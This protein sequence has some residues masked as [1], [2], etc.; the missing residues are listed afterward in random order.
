MSEG[1]ALCE[2]I[3]RDGRLADYRIIEINPALQGMLGVGPE[4]AGTL[5][6]E[7]GPV[8]RPW[9]EVCERVLLEG[10]PVGFEFHNRSTG[11]WHEIRLTRVAKDRIAQFFFD[12]T[13]R[14]EAQEHQ[15]R[16]FDELN[17]RVKNSLTM[18]SALLQMQART[19]APEAR[20]A[21]SR[22]VSRVAAI[23]DVHG[24]LHA[25]P[26]GGEAETDLAPY[27]ETLCKRLE[28]SLV[29]GERIVIELTAE[30]VKVTVD[31]AAPLGM[32]VN[33][34]VT[35]SVKHAYP[36]PSEGVIAV[37]LARSP[38]GMVLTVRDWGP[39]VDKSAQPSIG[40]GLGMN[41][42][43]SLARQ[44]GA[45]FTTRSGPGT[46]FELRLPLGAPARQAAS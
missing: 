45:T 42:I 13:E 39:G 7:G 2:P 37:R 20:E 12:I 17:H 14:K 38:S 30:P 46:T 24:A 10:E 21:L 31:Q 34:L 1:F 23:S 3:W 18:V 19:A 36:P 27:L 29:E 41:L 5:L 26:G 4:A 6:S 35:N 9:L 16:L 11:R 43:S 8:N 15:A 28:D 40:G 33:E 32:I 22:A 25:G 44:I